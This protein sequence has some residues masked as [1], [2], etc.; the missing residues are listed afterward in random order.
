[1]TAVDSKSNHP[2]FLV[3]YMCSGK[4]TLGRALARALG[5]DFI[6]L[7]DYIESRQGRTIAEIFAADGEAAFRQAEADALDE[8]IAA[9][10]RSRQVIALGGGTPCRPGVMDRLNDAGM[11]VHLTAPVARLVERLELGAAQRPLVAGKSAGELTAFVTAMLAE[12]NPY[13]SLARYTFDSSR[14]EDQAQIDESVARFIAT[15]LS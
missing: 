9:S 1:M 13:Y 2:I 10:G 11:A 7:D 12:R 15:L 5:T 4:S 3:G 6:D 8:V 14:L